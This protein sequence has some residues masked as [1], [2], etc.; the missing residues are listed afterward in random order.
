MQLVDFVRV[1]GEHFKSLSEDYELLGVSE[2]AEKDTAAFLGRFDQIF[3]DKLPDGLKLSSEDVRNVPENSFNG[4]LRHVKAKLVARFAWELLSDNESLLEDIVSEMFPITNEQSEEAIQ[5][6]Y[7]RLVGAEWL[8]GEAFSSEF[9]SDFMASLGKVRVNEFF[10]LL[11]MVKYE[12]M[13]LANKRIDDRGLH[14]LCQRMH[15]HARERVKPSSA[16]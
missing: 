5:R 6:V 12:N 7:K 10:K 16:R 9:W 8:L 4:F 13:K 3:Q 11:W 14:T 2:N 15:A 1:I